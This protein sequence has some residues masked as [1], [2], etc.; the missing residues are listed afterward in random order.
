[1]GTHVVETAGCGGGV[2][3]WRA[4]GVAGA[5]SVGREGWVSGGGGCCW[6]WWCESVVDRGS[7]GLTEQEDASDSGGLLSQRNGTVNSS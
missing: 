6:W 2:A 5:V 4:G 7:S 3:V 1:M